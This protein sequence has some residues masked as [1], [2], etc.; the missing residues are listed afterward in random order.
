MINTIRIRDLIQDISA[1]YADLTVAI[2]RLNSVMDGLKHIENELDNL[3]ETIEKFNKENIIFS[4]K[5]L[6]YH[7]IND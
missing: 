7:E 6:E 1:N 3:K 5:T 2:E 4:N